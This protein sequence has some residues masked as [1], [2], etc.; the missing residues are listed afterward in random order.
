[1]MTKKRWFLPLLTLACSVDAT[2]PVDPE[3]PVSATVAN[4]APMASGEIPAQ[5]L[6]GPGDT[7]SVDMAAHFTDPDGNALT[8]AAASS[9]TA[10]VRVAVAG[11]EATLTARAVGE[12]SV[13]MTARDPSGLEA[14]AVFVATVTE[15]PDRAA[16]AALYNATDGPNWTNNDGWLTDRPLRDWFGVEVAE[17]AW[18]TSISGRV[19]N[20]YLPDNALSGSIP[21]EVGDIVFLERLLLSEN[22]LAGAI[23]PELA[24]LAN[25][26]YL[27][28]SGNPD[29]C[30]PDDSRLRAWLPKV[31][32]TGLPCA[33]P[34]VR[35]LSRAL[36]RAD[37][38]GV[39]LALPD[40]LRSPATVNISDPGVVGATVTDGWL[41]LVPR[42]SGSADVELVPAGG[43]GVPAIAGVVVREPIGTYGIDIV[44][45]EQPAPVGYEEALTAA[46]DWWSGILDGTEWPDRQSACPASGAKATADELL[47]YANHVASFGAEGFQ[48][49]V[50]AAAYLCAGRGVSSAGAGTVT[51]TR[52]WSVYDVTM[53]HEI[54][55]LLGLGLTWDGLKTEDGAHYIGPRAV[56]AYRDGGGD[57]DLP[58]V[59]V[60]DYYGG[61]WHRNL[62]L[63][64]LMSPHPCGD[65]PNG[66]EGYADGISLAALADMGYTVD[67]SKATPWWKEGRP[68]R[69][70][71]PNNRAPT[72]VGSIAA[73]TVLAGGSVTVNVAGNFSDPDGDPISFAA[74]SSDV[75]VATTSESGSNVTINGVS[76]GSAT[77]TV[78]ATDPGG[79]SAN[80][81]VS[82]TVT[83]GG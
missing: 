29:L 74:A 64:E 49:L 71:N 48:S 22:N 66:Q 21:P 12:T 73:Q 63:C 68:P 25:L 67:M 43:G 1:M 79:L 23:P 62:V 61:H 47:I 75:A 14:R 15:H 83:G 51:V 53:R 40:Y 31:R 42:S 10:V 76:A 78:T 28:L 16:L 70:P 72:A 3:P 56:E 27:S 32:A 59:P 58:G 9:D 33:D 65:R 18:R 38:N 7:L 80:Q 81:S 5:R 2:A 34:S 39:S 44:M 17:E 50:T 77:V 52:D 46:A 20:L 54:G 13:T 24:N 30:V 19:V 37:G 6:A 55:H 82:V 57:P 26:E 4:R 8:F 35:L 11:T 69:P 41:D 36:M 60:D 45:M